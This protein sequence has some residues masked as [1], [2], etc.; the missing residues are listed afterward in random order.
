MEN[1]KFGKV[2]NTIETIFT[3]KDLSQYVLPTVIVIGNE[4]TGKSSLLENIT[5][6]QIFP[7][8]SKIC[9]K[10]PIKVKLTNSLQCVYSIEY[11]KDIILVDKKE[12]IYKNV[13]NI[14]QNI[15]A[16][17]IQT[18]EIT[19]NITE[20]KL[21]TFEFYDL[22][23]I[24][25]YPPNMAKQTTDL[26]KK[27]LKDKNAIVLCV[28]PSTTPRMTSC[29][30][31]ALI[32]EIKMEENTILALTMCDRIQEENIEELLVKRI[33]RLSDEIKDLNFAGYIG[34]V[35]RNHQ[36]MVK[37]EDNDEYEKKWFSENIINVIPDEYEQ[38]KELIIE[39]ITI[40]NLIIKMDDLYNKYIQT[41]WKPKIIINIKDKIKDLKNDYDNL[42]IHIEDIPNYINEIRETIYNMIC[43]QINSYDRHQFIDDVD[44]IGETPMLLKIK[45]NARYD[46]KFDEVI[47]S[48]MQNNYYKNKFISNLIN[49]LLYLIKK[50]QSKL[51]SIDTIKKDDN[52]IKI[53][54][55]R[56]S[57][58]IKK[59]FNDCYKNLN[60]LYYNGESYNDDC[61]YDK[62]HRIKFTERVDKILTIYEHMRLQHYAS[63]DNDFYDKEIF[64]RLIYAEFFGK[65][66]Y[67]EIEIENFIE[68][69]ETI[70]ERHL[71]RQKIKIAE[72]HLD[73]IKSL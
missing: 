19:I 32:S 60:I 28:V 1:S 47:L 66:T 50:V 57:T 11:K 15:S 70:H 71:L 72:E 38:Y 39:N 43:E 29:Q 12:D 34:V 14:M 63:P 40:S 9:T 36:D 69:D 2:K 73:R 23:G 30:S 10:C 16:D 4:S 26:C 45:Y 56:F 42:G 64:N 17:S 67:P 31:I 24:R 5:K 53:R 13:C 49:K 68:C 35:N 7:R 58:L 51:Y 41:D 52:I 44:E 18:D 3:K 22:P 25:A 54:L 6:C 37:L 62:N 20:D 48:V 59:I 21:P 65:L 27:Y 46:K 61:F 55:R 33:I 8:D